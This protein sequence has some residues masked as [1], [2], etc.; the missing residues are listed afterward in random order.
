MQTPAASRADRHDAANEKLQVLVVEDNPADADLAR[1]TLPET[2][3]VS[4]GVEFAPRL[5]DAIERLK[6]GGLDLI[7]VDLGLPD[8]Q[9]LETFRRI[10]DAAP[11]VAT[12]VLTGNDDLEQAITAVRDGAQDYLVKGQ[13][14]GGVLQRTAR[15]A[16]ERKRMEV[17]LKNPAAAERDGTAGEGRRLGVR[18]RHQEHGLDGGGVPDPRSRPCLTAGCG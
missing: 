1:E 4:F 8:S 15:Y 13:V 2:G 17:A 9:G 10:R 14:G 3:L 6:R 11:H 5:S 12:I 18:H 7:I 16:V